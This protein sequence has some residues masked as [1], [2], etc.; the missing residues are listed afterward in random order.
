MTKKHKQRKIIF[1]KNYFQD[2]FVKQRDKVKDKII[3]TFDLIEELQK[4]PVMYLKHID[5]TKGLYEIRVQ[6]GGDIF[7]IFCFFDKEQLV[8]IA[9]DFQKKSQK[10]PK[11]EI[12]KALKIKKEYENEKK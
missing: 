3:W 4:V 6:S 12:E 10:T 11:Y 1:Y 7:R 2:F 5:N 8:V 9:N